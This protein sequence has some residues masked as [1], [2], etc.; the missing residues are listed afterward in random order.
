MQSQTI[1]SAKGIDQAL[2]IANTNK[3]SFFL[4]VSLAISFRR[5]GKDNMVGAE[6]R[7]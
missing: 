3:L 4:V 1:K 5:W 6:V 2:N 7:D